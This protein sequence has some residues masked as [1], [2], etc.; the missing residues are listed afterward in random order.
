MKASP[1]LPAPCSV[2][3]IATTV[4]GTLICGSKEVD[5]GTYLDRFVSAAGG[6]DDWDNAGAIGQFEQ[7]QPLRLRCDRIVLCG[8]GRWMLV[9]EIGELQ[10][11]HVVD[12]LLHFRRQRRVGEADD[13]LIDVD[14]LSG[15]I[16][17]RDR[18]SV[19]LSNRM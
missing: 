13:A 9:P 18:T 15:L 19:V 14:L 16:D 7:S 17:H 4:G 12:E 10:R 3:P 2:P 5:V 8:A 6:V 1:L 11:K